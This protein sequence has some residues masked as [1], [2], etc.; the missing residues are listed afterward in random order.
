MDLVV[1]F[2]DLVGKSRQGYKKKTDRTDVDTITENSKKSECGD[3]IIL[4]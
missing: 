1:G 2:R 3:I 4:Y